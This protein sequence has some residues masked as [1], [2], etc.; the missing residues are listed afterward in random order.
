MVA[1]GYNTE[2]GAWFATEAEASAHERDCPECQCLSESTAGEMVV[3][4]S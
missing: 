4:T 2:C 3:V 1:H